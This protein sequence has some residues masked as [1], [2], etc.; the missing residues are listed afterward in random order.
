MESVQFQE[1]LLSRNPGNITDGFSIEEIANTGPQ[2]REL[3]LGHA[4]TGVIMAVDQLG[5]LR[6]GACPQGMDE[7]G[8]RAYTLVITDNEELSIARIEPGA[9]KNWAGVAPWAVLTPFALHGRRLT[10]DEVQNDLTDGKPTL[11]AVPLIIM[12]P[13][14]KD[15]IEGPAR[16]QG[17]Q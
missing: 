11:L 13:P 1:P 15:W 10:Q 14:G 6:M 16:D 12:G 5:Y 8:Q 7:G 2:I 17:I 9:L 3:V 4:R